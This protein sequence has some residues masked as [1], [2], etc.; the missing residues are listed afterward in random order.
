[1]KMIAWQKQ[2][3]DRRARENADADLFGQWW[4]GIDKSIEAADVR[5]IDIPTARS[6]ILDYEWLGTMPAVL[7]HCFGIYFQGHLGGVVCYGPEYSENLG[8]WDK[9]EFTGKLILLSRGAC[10][11]W[12]PQH[13]ASA[14]IRRSMRLLPG[15]YEVVTATVDAE[16]G[17]VGTIYQ[18]CGFFYVGQ[19]AK[20]NAR[21]PRKALMLPGGQ[22]VPE[23]R[24][25]QQFGSVKQA[26]E[27]IPGAS[28][29]FLEYKERYFAFRGSRGA[30]RNNYARIAHLIAAFPKRAARP[31][32]ESLPSDVSQVRPL[33]AAPNFSVEGDI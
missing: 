31:D 14:L 2:I 3:R 20:N 19:M 25:R 4:A 8:V 9:Y 32:D 10:V 13:S 23:R 29:V 7:W 16:A 12:A 22:I 27:A 18:A 1:M 26:C 30:R 11:H 17:E 28:R 5:P 6:V 15:K 21:Q 33:G 24:A